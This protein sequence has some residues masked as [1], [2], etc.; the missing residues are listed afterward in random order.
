[1]KFGFGMYYLIDTRKV[2]KDTQETVNRVY[3]REL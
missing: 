3:L 1:M 2:W